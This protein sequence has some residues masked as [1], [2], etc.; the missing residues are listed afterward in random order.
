[1]TVEVNAGS[2]PA[3]VLFGIHINRLSTG[4]PYLPFGLFRNAA[5]AGMH[6]NEIQTSCTPITYD[7]SSADAFISEANS[8]GAQ[9]LFTVFLTPSCASSNPGDTNCVGG[10]KNSGGC[11]HPVDLNCDGTGTDQFYISFVQAVAQRYGSKINYYEVWNEPDVGTEWSSSG[12]GGVANAK[13]LMLARMAQ[14]LKA[15]V[16][17]VNPQAKIVSASPSGGVTAPAAFQNGLAMAASSDI[18]GFHG[19]QATPEMLLSVIIADQASASA[20]GAGTKPFWDTEF[21]W[22]VGNDP[23][24]DSDNRE[25][26][27]ARHYLIQAWAVQSVIWFGEEYTNTGQF[28]DLSNSD[29]RECLTP[30][31]NLPNVA[32]FACSAAPAYAQVHNWLAGQTAQ[33]P[34]CSQS[35]SQTANHCGDASPTGLWEVKIG[36]SMAIWDNALTC[37]SGSCQT[38]Q[39]PVSGFTQ[40]VD[41]N[42]NVTP[43]SGSTATVSLKPILLQSS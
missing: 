2:G 3:D 36:T 37:S 31:T 38:E 26:W 18:L 6:W 10:A 5:A 16:Q 34:T 23:L 20:A 13:Y 8:N 12:C 25:A 9:V 21:S 24:L 33:Q 29:G 7:W 4:W 27:T 14:D 42:G 11:D 17:A 32:G 15:T 19:Y 30:A 35:P 40:S 43:I 28:F 39:V 1:M 41:L 22:N